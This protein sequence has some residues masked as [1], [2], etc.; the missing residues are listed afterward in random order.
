MRYSPTGSEEMQGEDMEG[1]MDLLKA[2]VQS[3]KHSTEPSRRQDEVQYALSKVREMMGYFRKGEAN[4]PVRYP[5]ALAEILSGFPRQ[6]IDKVTSPY[7]IAAKSDFMPSIKELK[8]ACEDE[9]KHFDL[10]N[11]PKVPFRTIKYDRKPQVTPNLWVPCDNKRYEEMCARAKHPSAVAGKMS[12]FEE[13]PNSD[14]VLKAGIW[15]PLG[16][17]EDRPTGTMKPLQMPVD[18]LKIEEPPPVEGED[19]FVF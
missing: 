19:D 7:G 3:S 14:G 18:E 2:K 8:E 13:R 1:E 5:L 15:I 12:R 11:R 17:W 9:L 6:V 16:W 10:L 4:D